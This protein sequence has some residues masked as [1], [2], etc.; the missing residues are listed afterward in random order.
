MELEIEQHRI[1]NRSQQSEECKEYNRTLHY[2]VAKVPQN[3]QHYTWIA[4]V[5]HFRIGKHTSH[6][7]HDETYITLPTR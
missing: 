2:I 1:V 4:L 5:Q 6:Y 7:P 3:M